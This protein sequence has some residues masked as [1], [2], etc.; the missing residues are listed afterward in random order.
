MSHV[1]RMSTLTFLIFFFMLHTT[2]S[3]GKLIFCYDTVV[4]VKMPKED[5]PA[6]WVLFAITAGLL[7]V[8]YGLT[9]TVM[10]QYTDVDRYLVKNS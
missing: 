10:L 9:H 5:Y 4:Y 8:S 7:S 3:L 6:L 1:F 2:G